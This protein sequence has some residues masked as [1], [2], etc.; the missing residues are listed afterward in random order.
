MN[1]NTIHKLSVQD[2]H[3][4]KAR[5]EPIAMVTAYDFPTAGF[6]DR[7][8]VDAILVGDSIGNTVLGYDSTLP[9]SMDEMTVHC[10]AVSKAV[11]RAFVIGDM[12][13]MSYQPSTRDA[14][15]NAGRLMSEGGVDA[16]KLEGAGAA[17]P[18]VRTITGAGIPV[19]GHLGLTPQSA[20]ALGGLKVQ[21]RHAHQAERL[22]SDALLLEDAGVFALVLEAIPAPLAEVV[23]SR[24]DIPTIGIGAGVHCDGQV[25]VMHDMFGL[26]PRVPRFAKQYADLGAAF[27]EG[28]ASYRSDVKARAFPDAEHSYSMQAGELER[29]GPLVSGGA[30]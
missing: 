13:Y 26:S 18:I 23:T 4:L 22:L 12:P 14:V 15:L 25:L 7:A 3:A 24:L 20:A 11:R 17:L 1:E 9:V 8:G 28:F 5:G 16:V 30:A 29:L 21:A 10:R 6:A 19:M 2:F 27:T